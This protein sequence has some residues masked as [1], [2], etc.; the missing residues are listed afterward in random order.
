MICEYCE[1]QSRYK[2]LGVEVC[3][4]HIQKAKEM[5]LK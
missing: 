2:F 5:I 1:K 3:D 4:Q